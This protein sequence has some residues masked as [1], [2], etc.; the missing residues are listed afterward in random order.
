[1]LTEGFS[2][3]PHRFA[4]GYVEAP[5]GEDVHWVMTRDNQKVYRWRPRAS[6]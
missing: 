3:Q 4:L 2:Y 5:R 6:S 1:M